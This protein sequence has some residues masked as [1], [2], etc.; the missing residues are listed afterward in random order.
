MIAPKTAAPKA[1]PISSP[2]RERGAATVSQASA[3]AQV[4]VLE[5]PWT[6]RARP[7][8]HGPAASA[9]PKLASASSMRPRTTARFGPNRIAAIP[10]GMPP[11]ES[12]RPERADEQ[13]RA[14]LREPEL[15]GVAGHERR[16]RAEEHRVD[17]DDR[18]DEDEQPAHRPTLPT[19]AGLR[20]VDERTL[21]FFNTRRRSSAN[22]ASRRSP[23]EPRRR[24]TQ[25]QGVLARNGI[26]ARG[27]R[28]CLRHKKF[29]EPGALSSATPTNFRHQP[30][31][32]LLRP[33]G[34]DSTYSRPVLAARGKLRADPARVKRP[35]S[36]D[37]ANCGLFFSH[38]HNLPTAP[39]TRPSQ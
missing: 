24:R 8:A 10:P 20:S 23:S 19:G 1:I 36:E 5:K 7:S 37:V 39:F 18:A 31:G 14:G 21:C 15:V 13:P 12:A 29:S 32:I 27:S 34:V 11:S 16:E 2:R 30:C 28:F 26:P 3:P 25:L 4:V 22:Q 38:S 35:K 6:K 33:I 9:K 17:E